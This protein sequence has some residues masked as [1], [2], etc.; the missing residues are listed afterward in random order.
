[1]A[2]DVTVAVA[3]GGVK[4]ASVIAGAL[5]VGEE[6]VRMVAAPTAPYK[7]QSSLPGKTVTETVG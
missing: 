7:V 6:D 5:E 2:K 1:M 4:A 3:L